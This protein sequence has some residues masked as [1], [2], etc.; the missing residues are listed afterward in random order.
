MAD[1][2][3]H[4]RQE[5]RPIRKV[6]PRTCLPEYHYPIEPRPLAQ[7]AKRSMSLHRLRGRLMQEIRARREPEAPL[8]AKISR[9]ERSRSMRKM[10]PVQRQQRLSHDGEA[11]RLLKGH[12]KHLVLE[13]QQRSCR[14]LSCQ[15]LPPHRR[16]VE[17]KITK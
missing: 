11:Q 5:L 15:V 14:R 2:L 12:H 1:L 8:P 6:R 16:K 4:H 7:G 3:S 13:N 9:E 10:Q 17:R